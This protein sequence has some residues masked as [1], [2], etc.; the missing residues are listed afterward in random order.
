VKQAKQTLQQA[1][2]NSI[3]F[4]DGSDQSDNAIVISQDP[5]GNSPVDSPDNTTVT[6]T[7]LGNGNNGGNNNGGTNI[8][9][10][11]SG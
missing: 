10:G 1:G 11:T 9:G 8:F 4:A 2:F 7:T 6:L 5:A 3:Q